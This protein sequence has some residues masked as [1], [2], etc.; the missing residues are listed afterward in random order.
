MIPESGPHLQKGV[1][2]QMLK[3]GKFGYHEAIS[4]IV[5][6][7]S[8]RV[9]F[10]SP[11]RVVELVGTAG[12][13]MTIISALTAASLF[14]FI[15]LLLKRFPQKNIMQITD[16]VLGKWV[17][18]IVSFI[19]GA[20]LMIILSV[21]LREFTEVLKTY[22]LPDSPPSFI[23]VIF[24]LG[25][26]ALSFM[27]LETIA[28]YAKFLI[29]MLLAGYV[30]VIILSFQSFKISQL[31]PLL[32]NGLDKTIMNGFLRSSFYGDVI[33]IGIIAG[34]LQSTK[35]IKYIGFSSI[36]I[37]GIIASSALLAFSLVFS[38]TTAQELTAPMYEMAALIDY[39]GF[40]QQMEPIFLFLWN[41]G[42]FI[43]T[44]ILFYCVIMVYC[45]IFKIS[46]KRPIILPLATLVYCLSLIPKSISEVV[47]DQVEFIRSWGWL[48]YFLPSIIVLVIAVIRKKKGESQDA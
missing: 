21:N 39:G 12:W 30:I 16:L 9:F 26:I 17:G 2:I 34:S 29:Y 38:Y 18:S 41:F 8:I 27:G 44:S 25:V 36:F 24:M 4:I 28:R 31:F 13:Y 19:L 15:Y 46:D 37:S 45:H 14:A 43:E 3:E 5:I 35:E 23:M 42:S 11:G 1:A 33:I 47:G 7:I 22:V 48:F 20:F 32:G 10:T 6:T 40:L